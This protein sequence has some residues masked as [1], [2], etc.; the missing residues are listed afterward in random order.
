MNPD[1][2][3]IGSL[4][5]HT[6]LP[7]FSAPV[8]SIPGGYALYAAAGARVFS[9]NAKIISRVGENY[10]REW[11]DD[12]H[13]DGIDTSA[14]LVLPGYH[15]HR[16]FEGY[17]EQFERWIDKP[18]S[19]FL[20]RGFEFPKELFSYHGPPQ[21]VDGETTVPA[22]CPKPDRVPAACQYPDAALIGPVGYRTQ[23]QWVN[24]YRSKGV[25]QIALEFDP[26]YA[27][28]RQLDKIKLLIE[29]VDI[30]F[31][32]EEDLI[33]I[34]R[35]QSITRWKM[36]E[37]LAEW[38][39][40]LIITIQPLNQQLLYIPFTNTKWI[41]PAYQSTISDPSGHAAVFCGAFLS[42]YVLSRDP[43]QS[44]VYGN[45]VASICMETT[46]YKPILEALPELIDLR[47]TSLR[48]RVYKV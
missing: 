21:A 17:S 46:G 41:L 20:D 37:R 24:F 27:D 44:S 31:I 16:Y 5:Q 6:I 38:D 10:S 45:V 22:L 11:L 3:I 2:V 14:V 15:D 43:I 28:P 9:S 7:P 29:G 33:T 12:L 13:R 36:M 25:Q 8:V 42:Q 39:I 4:H 1:L 26:S 32:H 23:F 48:E 47:A 35:G 18:I 30:L 19:H 34:F 40:K